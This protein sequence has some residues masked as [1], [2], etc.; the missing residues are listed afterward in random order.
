MDINS[1]LKQTKNL[2]EEENKQNRLPDEVKFPKAIESR[3]T[4]VQETIFPAPSLSRELFSTSEHD[5]SPPVSVYYPEK[6]QNDIKTATK[7]IVSNFKPG[8]S[9]SNA[10]SQLNSDQMEA[11]MKP[12]SQVSLLAVAG[13]LASDVRETVVHN[14]AENSETLQTFG[15]KALLVALEENEV[16]PQIV[17]SSFEPE[18]FETVRVKA[19]LSSILN[20]A[21]TIG[22]EIGQ[23]AFPEIEKQS[24]QNATVAIVKNLQNGLKILDVPEILSEKELETIKKAECQVALLSLAERLEKSPS[25]RETIIQEVA[26]NRENT[27]SFG[28]KALCVAIEQSSVEAENVVSLFKQSDFCQQNAKANLTQILKEAHEV[29]T[30]CGVNQSFLADVTQDHVRKAVSTIVAQYKNS[31]SVQE[32]IAL[33]D[34]E[35]ITI[36]ENPAAQCALFK[37]AERLAPSIQETGFPEIEETNENSQ[38]FGTKALLLAIEETNATAE[39]VVASFRETDFRQNPILAKISNIQERKISSCATEAVCSFSPIQNEFMKAAEKIVK[40][41]N[42]GQTVSNVFDSLDAN[43]LDVI[44]SEEAQVA[45]LSIA[46]NVGNALEV[47]YTTLLELA[48]NEKMT[49]TFG[50]KALLFALEN[51][52][53]AFE[54]CAASFDP[55]DLDKNKVKAKISNI[56]S[57]VQE[58]RKDSSDKF[59][60]MKDEL[61][62]ATEVIARNIQSGIQVTETL[63]LLNPKQVQMIHT[64][65]AQVALLCV[66][67][68][69]GNAMSIHEAIVRDQKV[70]KEKENAKTFGLKALQV[71]L[72]NTNTSPEMV[73]SSFQSGDF[74]ARKVKAKISQIT[75]EICGAES[76]TN[77]VGLFLEDIMLKDMKKIAEIILKSQPGMTVAQVP[78]ILSEAEIEVT[79]RPEAQVAFMKTVERCRVVPNIHET[80]VREISKNKEAKKSFGIKSLLMAKENSD[81]TPEHIVSCLEQNDIDPNLAK[82]SLSQIMKEAHSIEAFQPEV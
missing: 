17:V 27:Q 74:E 48:E 25:V 73:A 60:N 81:V 78:Q 4:N 47:H 65:E 13:T 62:K 23:S 34:P 76:G 20:E 32:A 54:D 68:R 52:D 75:A 45:L 58:L 69:V 38:H 66:A 50:I 10:L 5:L 77:E 15:L 71:A 56:L 24:I 61:A 59:T 41:F 44:K 8:L 72:E 63:D 12:E 64:D 57:E 49:K 6:I 46:E 21:Y 9:V 79:T 51:Y 14:L 36:L 28:L 80:I 37:I 55:A 16:L 2:K 70:S 35:T 82:A 31:L 26:Q 11:V 67:E 43:Q 29:E 42:T 39:I 33:L 30:R 53:I 3:K 19:K 7:L 18:N 22:T 1:E 40:N